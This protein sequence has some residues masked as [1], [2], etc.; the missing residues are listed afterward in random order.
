MPQEA[1]SQQREIKGELFRLNQNT[2]G[3]TESSDA[4]C[5]NW[6]IRYSF[7]PIWT[8]QVPVGQEV[9]ITPEHRFG[10]YLKD[11][12]GSAAEWHDAQKVRVV[13]WDADLKRM[14]II[15]EGRYVE[16]KEMQDDEKMARFDLL[17]QPIRLDAGDW[18][19]IEGMCDSGTAAVYTIDLDD[20]ACYF[21]M[22]MLR[23][24][25]TLH[26]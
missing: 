26:K 16:S 15:Y 17:N 11:D 19:Y 3:I 6:A 23:V 2:T 9:V 18:I 12:E 10:V 25:P 21:S 22:E 1:T 7:A 4:T 5:E 13:V 24:R 20:D 14:Q 8:W